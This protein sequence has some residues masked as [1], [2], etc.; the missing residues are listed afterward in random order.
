MA[1]VSPSKRKRGSS[2]SLKRR[3]WIV[4]SLSVTA[5]LAAAIAIALAVKK[6][7][8]DIETRI[9]EERRLL[10][11]LQNRQAPNECPDPELMSPER[12]QELLERFGGHEAG[13]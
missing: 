8:C 1:V 7:S 4:V 9:P 2:A 11:E 13:G 3:R 5:L 12:C 10:C 6:E